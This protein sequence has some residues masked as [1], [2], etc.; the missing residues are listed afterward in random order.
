MKGKLSGHSLYTMSAVQILYK[1]HL[2]AGSGTLT[3]CNGA[4]CKEVFPN[5]QGGKR[6]DQ[7]CCEPTQE[8]VPLGLLEITYS[9]PAITILPNDLVFVI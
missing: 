7:R 9:K 5:L 4:A 8:I 1:D 2:I 3:R 6:N